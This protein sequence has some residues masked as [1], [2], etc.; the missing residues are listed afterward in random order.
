MTQIWKNQGSE[1]FC[2]SCWAKNPNKKVKK[3]TAKPLS[4]KSAKQTKLDVLYGIARE[5][6]LK[7]H[8]FCEA[9]IPGLCQVNATDIHHKIG[10]GKYLLDTTTFMAVCRTCHGWIETNPKD[11]KILGFSVSRERNSG[12]ESHD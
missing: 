8:S 9:Q 2:K 10:R 5:H 7:A 3:L 6:Y 1:K 12:D 11:A 4:K